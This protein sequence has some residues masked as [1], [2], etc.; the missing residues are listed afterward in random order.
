[1]KARRDVGR[2]K[3]WGTEAGQDGPG[4][5]SSATHIKANTHH[6]GSL[7][8]GGNFV[9]SI[10]SFLPA[11]LLQWRGLPRHAPVPAP[12]ADSID[13]VCTGGGQRNWLLYHPPL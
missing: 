5:K 11:F 4:G 6:T 8:C 9:V 7:L 12:G 1:M 3:A 10:C 2:K 13:S